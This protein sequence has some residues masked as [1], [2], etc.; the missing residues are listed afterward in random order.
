MM[1]LRRLLFSLGLGDLT[2]CK[3]L[4]FHVVCGDYVSAPKRLPSN[5]F[6]FC[7]SAFAV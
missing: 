2:C 3:A 1:G 4:C 7:V 6:N 5:D